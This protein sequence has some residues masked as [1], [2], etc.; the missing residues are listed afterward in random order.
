MTKT[1]D[2]QAMASLSRTYNLYNP[3]KCPC[4]PND[5]Q[6]QNYLH[7]AESQPCLMM[8]EIVIV[9]CGQSEAAQNVALTES[10]FL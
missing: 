6:L 5:R 10:T 3:E 4:I 7:P 2:Q 1:Q 9:C 8:R